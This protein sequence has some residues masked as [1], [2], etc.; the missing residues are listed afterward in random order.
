MCG[1]PLAGETGHLLTHM[2]KRAENNRQERLMI[3]FSDRARSCRE[4]AKT[5]RALL[6]R[7]DQETTTDAFEAN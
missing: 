7:T 5:L 3:R 4:D 1:R 2:S 6:L